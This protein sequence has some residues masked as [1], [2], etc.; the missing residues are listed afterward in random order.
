[1]NIKKFETELIEF[2]K[3][4]ALVD[5]SV[6]LMERCINDEILK[7]ID[8]MVRMYR[9]WAKKHIVFLIEE[10]LKPRQDCPQCEWNRSK[11][12][13]CNFCPE[14]GKGLK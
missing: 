9:Q 13:K 12:N 5:E 1:M 7:P 4:V 6:E 10:H 8:K 2:D 11:M 14:C 3:I